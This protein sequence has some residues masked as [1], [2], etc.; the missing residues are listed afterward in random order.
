MCG[1]E[2]IINYIR[3][4]LDVLNNKIITFYTLYLHY[5][6]RRIFELESNTDTSIVKCLTK[7]QIQ[8]FYQ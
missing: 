7:L 3:D 1:G 8:T 2:V 4:S 5:K 6:R